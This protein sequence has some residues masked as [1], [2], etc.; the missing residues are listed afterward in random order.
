MKSKV[1]RE[2]VIRLIETNQNK[3][4]RLAYRYVKNKEDALDI[5]HNAVV[6]ALQ[7]YPSLREEQY[8]ETW[9]CRIVIN[10][11]LAFLKR[12]KRTISF[13]EIKNPQKEAARERFEEKIDLQQAIERL[14]L[15]LQTIII[16]RFFEG[17]KIE[18]VAEITDTNL[19]T[20]KSRLYKAL[21]LMKKGMEG[22]DVR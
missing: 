21:D 11:S 6:I 3:L 13:E 16:L 14:P 20:T 10:E 5:T 8:L 19:S 9:L 17:Y 18:E 2:Q 15:Q 7:K 12:A 22:Y 4:Y 1:S